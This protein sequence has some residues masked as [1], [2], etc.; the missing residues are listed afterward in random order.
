MRNPKTG[1]RLKADLD[2]LALA[3]FGLAEISVTNPNV[4][5]EAGMLKGMGKPVILLRSTN[6]DTPVPFD[7]FGTYRAEY[8]ISAR[9]AKRA[10][11]WLEEELDKAMET[12]FHM[13]PELQRVPK[14]N[15]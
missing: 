1:Q 12:V 10:F 15:G 9:G 5:F 6:S 7:I 2:S 8:D 4:L 13:L 14:W 3:H 11:V